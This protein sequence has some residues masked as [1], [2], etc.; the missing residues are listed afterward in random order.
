MPQ[1]QQKGVNP[2]SNDPRDPVA[3]RIAIAALGLAL[4]VVF[5]GI[6]WIAAVHRFPWERG[7]PIGLWFAAG[8]IGGVFVGALL[9]FSLRIRSSDSR[10]SGSDCA[11][12]VYASEHPGHRCAW[13][14]IA[15]A[16]ALLVVGVAATV[17]GL[18]EDRMALDVLGATIAGVL[19][20]LPIPS[21][22]RR[23]R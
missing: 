4:S 15:G 7:V 22:A 21:P 3:Y 10:R 20:G 16:T 17:I 18:V 19:L 23:N 6:C 14:S 8:A 5:A 9:P 2:M 11:S 1:R 13:G 12:S